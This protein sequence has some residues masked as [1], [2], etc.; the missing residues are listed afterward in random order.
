MIVILGDGQTGQAVVQFCKEQRLPFYHVK[1]TSLDP[2]EIPLKEVTLCVTSPGIPPSNSLIQYLEKRLPVVSE[3]EFAIRMLPKARTNTIVITGTNG[4]TSVTLLLAHILQSA[5]ISAQCIGNIGTPVISALSQTE[6]SIIEM[7]SF[8]LHYTFSPF[9]SLGCWLNF[10]P[11]HLDWHSSIDEYYHDKERLCQLVQGPCFVHDSIPKQT[12]QSVLDVSEKQ[13]LRF[14]NNTSSPIHI[15]NKS[16]ICDGRQAGKIPEN[17][18]PYEQQNYLAAWTL[19]T[20]IGISDSTIFSSYTHFKRPDHRLQKIIEKKGITF[21]NDS[22]STTVA[23]TSAAIESVDGPIALIAG[24]VAKSGS[25][26]SWNKYKDKISAIIAIGQAKEQI[27]QETCLPT[28]HASSLK[29]AITQ[30]LIHNPRSVLFSPGCSSFD[31]FKNYIDRGNQFKKA[32]SEILGDNY[33]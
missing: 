18:P 3:V 6:W 11:N 32:V 27:A 30:A 21:W 28:M 7:S 14:G 4:K 22:K 16:I 15:A 13:V 25:F 10:S 19:A 9:F 31:M 29:E 20:Q 23:S 2:K 26:A 5:G 1:N 33:G 12:E 8:Q 24:G 17:I